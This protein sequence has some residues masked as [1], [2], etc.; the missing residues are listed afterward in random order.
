MLQKRQSKWLWKKKNF[1]IFHAQS[2]ACQREKEKNKDI[3]GGEKKFSLYSLENN[4]NYNYKC[5]SI[6][7]ATVHLLIWRHISLKIFPFVGNFE[8]TTRMTRKIATHICEFFIHA[9][10]NE[11]YFS[12]LLL[13]WW[14]K[15][16]LERKKKKKRRKKKC[17]MYQ[18]CDAMRLDIL[19]FWNDVRNEIASLKF[20]RTT[21]FF[22]HFL[23]FNKRISQWNEKKNDPVDF[24]EFNR[25]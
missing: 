16:I 14:H 13:A 1:C 21:T 9:Q 12:S 23:Q 11:F 7:M 22:L 19:K 17:V 24:R 6:L 2:N 15:N 18:P 3:T 25:L 4:L 10:M 8:Q 20:K 5:P